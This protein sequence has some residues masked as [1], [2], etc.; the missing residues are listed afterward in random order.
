MDCHH[1]D[2]ARCRS[3]AWLPRSYDEQLAA[4][5]ERCA[6]LLAEHRSLTWRPPVRSVE[7]GFRNKAKLVVA[8]SIDDPSLGILGPDGG[9]DLRDCG[10]HVDTIRDALPVL[11]AFITRA[12]L[13]PYDVTTRR[14]E[15][16]LL[17][18]T[19]SPDHELMVRFV[20]RSQEPVTRLRKHLPWLHDALPRLVAASVNLQ[21]EHKAVLE[22]ATEIALTPDPVLRMNLNGIDLQLRPQSFFQTNTAVAATL[23]R[24]AAAWID[25][26]APATLWDLYCGV[27]GFALHAAS[28]GR[29]VLGIESSP[30][31]IA[32]A[33]STAAAAGLD[34]VTFVSGDAP[35]LAK[36]Q[37]SSPDLVVVNPPRRGI[38]EHLAAWLEASSVRRVVYSSCNP[39]SLAHD[40]AAMPSLV[41]VRGRVFDMFPQTAHAEVLVLLERS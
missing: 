4:K 17:L 27:G 12:A 30:E 19:A 5:Q 6:V 2:A 14:G 26:A 32:S 25:E 39:E 36:D 13:V 15:L 3:C 29:D 23:Y 21:P 33:R 24:E 34:G 37:G 9:V 40:L 20:T 1:Y 16:K 38:G 35:G 18:V 28:P 10:L 41:P 8:G 31:A 11:A 22:G 7:S